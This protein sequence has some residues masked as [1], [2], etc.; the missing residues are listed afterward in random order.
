V[1]KDHLGISLD[2]KYQKK[3]WS[4]RPLPS[5]MIDYAASDVLYLL[6]ISAN[7][8]DTLK[9]KGRIDWVLEECEILSNVRPAPNNSQPLFLKIKGAGRLS[10]RDLAALENILKIRQ[11][12]ARKKDRPLFKIFSN[13]SALTLATSCPKSLTA[14]QESGALSQ[15]QINMYGKRIVTAIRKTI[16]IPEDALPSYPKNRSPRPSS[17]VSPRVKALQ[18]WRNTKADTLGMDPGLIC[19][20][21]L[22]VR[23]AVLNPDDVGEMAA[24]EEM[25]N[26]QKE[27][28][29]KE[30]IKVLKKA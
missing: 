21:N 5:E 20:R 6:P 17:D 24:I 18:E 29:G 26:W 2:K 3:D 23:L 28:F 16:Q 1:V 30:I 10:P 15:H 7:L 14:L 9:R 19:N 4:K 22:A 11:E 8:I 13:R 27:T 25:K 12:V